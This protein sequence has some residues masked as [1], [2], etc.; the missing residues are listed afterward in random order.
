MTDDHAKES[1]R[2]FHQIPGELNHFT[3]TTRAPTAKWA[4]S[5]MGSKPNLA[6]QKE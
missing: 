3:G 4:P 2:H 1:Y 5:Q 6:A